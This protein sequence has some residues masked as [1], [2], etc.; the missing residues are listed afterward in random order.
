MKKLTITIESEV[1]EEFDCFVCTLT[2]ERDDGKKRVVRINAYR[3]KEKLCVSPVAH[4]TD[5]DGREYVK[6]GDYMANVK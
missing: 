1:V 4:I 5:Y 6:I 2:R 3:K